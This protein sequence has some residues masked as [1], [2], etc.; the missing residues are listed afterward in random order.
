[1]N[2]RA[3]GF[4]SSL[5]RGSSRS[6]AAGFSF[7]EMLVALLIFMAILGIV[8]NGY[9]SAKRNYNKYYKKYYKGG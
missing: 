8:F 9:N 4:T 3:P 5:L 7:L 2:G 6:G 1:M